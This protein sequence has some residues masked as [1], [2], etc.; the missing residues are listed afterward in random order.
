MSDT[1]VVHNTQARASLASR[2]YHGITINTL[3][4]FGGCIR[5]ARSLYQWFYPLDVKPDFVKVY[6]CRPQLPI[7]IFF[8]KTYDQTSP[9]TLP[10]IFTTHG[11]GFCI[12]NPEDDDRLNERF[13]NMHNILVIALNYRQII[14]YDYKQDEYFPGQKIGPEKCKAPAYPFPTP[15]HDVEALMLAIFADESIP[16]DKNRI[17]LSGYS[18]GGNIMLSACQLPSIREQIKPAAIVSVYSTVDLSIFVPEKV[19]GRYYKP[20]LKAGRRAHTTDYLAGIAPTF[21]WSYVPYGQELRDPLLS[22]YYAPREHLPPHIFFVASEL[23][24]LASESWRMANKIAGRPIP[25]IADMVG[26]RDVSSNPDSLILD[27]E[28]FAFEHVDANGKSS[29]RWLLVPDEVHGFDHLPASFLGP[30]D[31]VRSAHA[32]TVA[33]QRLVGEWLLSTAWKKES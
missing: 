32:K 22:P 17:A 16:I 28:R 14:R 19:A 9:Q 27:D 33:Y 30:E 4:T 23:D 8:P 24:M 12:G 15:I 29:V 7:R 6:D 20:E 13:A 25:A 10:T 31:A 11:G 18:A 3:Q 21:N 2:L 26:R 1:P 5:A